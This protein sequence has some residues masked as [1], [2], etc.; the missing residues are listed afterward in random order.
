MG[1]AAP[2]PQKQSA[3]NL[4]ETAVWIYFLTPY[5]QNDTFQCLHMTVYYADLH[6]CVC[7]AFTCSYKTD[8]KTPE[9]FFHCFSFRFFFAAE[10]ELVLFFRGGLYNEN[11][12]PKLLGFSSFYSEVTVKL[13]VPT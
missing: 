4:H 5:I 11:L 9:S 8:N 10:T 6:I 3:I 13:F 7:V 2:G 1:T 12:A